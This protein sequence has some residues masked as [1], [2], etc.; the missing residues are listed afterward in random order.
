[1]EGS[2]RNHQRLLNP[3]V[4]SKAAECCH[5]D[6]NKL[7]ADEARRVAHHD[8]MKSQVDRDVNAKIAE[9]AEHTTSA[10]ALQMDKVAGQFRG[11][12]IDEV[13]GKDREVR[14][15]RVLARVS[16]VIDYGF[17]VLYALLGI[18]L[19]LAMIA[20]K[21]SSGFVRVIHAVTDPFCWLFNGIV[22]SPTAGGFTLALP[23]VIALCVYAL[24][25]FGIT[26]L[27]RLIAHRK[28]EI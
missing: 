9:K 17:F 23:I 15:A 20:A 22:S 28:T 6:Q 1:M 14:R 10:E 4:G 11:K 25:H 26:R 3:A 2:A 13:A 21:P 16:Q 7:V 24:F 19:V 18:R 8:S 27:L 5:M 12:A